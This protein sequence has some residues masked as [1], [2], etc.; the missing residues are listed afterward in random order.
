MRR[1]LITL[2]SL[3]LLSVPSIALHAQTLNADQKMVLVESVGGSISPK[4][5]LASDSGLISAHNMMYRHSVTIYDATTTELI[6]TVPDTVILSDFGFSNYSGKYRG[7]PVEGAF[8]PDGKYLYFTNYAMY[9]KGFTKEG[10]DICSPASGYDKSFLSRVNLESKKIDAVYQVGSVPKVVQVS[11]DNKYILVSNWCSYTVTVISVESGKTV[12]S[13]KI[14][15]YPRGIA[16]TQDGQFA[17]VAEMGGSNIHRINLNDFSKTLIPIGSNPRAVVLSPDESTLYVTMNLSG[18]V[19][20]WDLLANKSIKSV[21]TGQAARSLDISNDGSALFVVNFKSD[22][23]SKVRTSDM[24]VLQTIK[25]CNE[26]I[27]VTY[28]SSTNQTW[29]ACYGGSLKVFANE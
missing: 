1:V 17:Y 9:G 6:A 28:D 20:A 15:R 11:P 22:T 26:P 14:G 2:L 12:K 24:K 4:S 29:V 27:G 25:V 23:L 3:T 8:S 19:Q 7:A 5:V 10:H 13:I 16:I 18:K 21:K